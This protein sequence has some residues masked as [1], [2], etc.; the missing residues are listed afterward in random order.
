[1]EDIETRIAEFVRNQ[2]VPHIIFHGASGTG[3]RTILANMLAQI[4]HGV[5]R[6]IDANVLRVNCAHTKGIKYIRDDI[7]SFAKV[8][9]QNSVEVPFKSIVLYNADHLTADAQSALRRS[10]ELFS[11]NT[12]FFIVVR[13][14][15]KMLSPILSRFCE[16]HVPEQLDHNAN[17]VN[18]HRLL[19][20]P[21]LVQSRSETI[22]AD[23]AELRAVS[24]KEQ[25]EQDG[26]V[27][28]LARSGVAV[29]AKW[30]GAGICADEL[31]R[32]LMEAEWLDDEARAATQLFYSCTAPEI[33]NENLLMFFILDFVLVRSNHAFKV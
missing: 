28:D 1:M 6:N 33:K 15:H 27:P 7:K 2:R 32:V 14:K 24:G 22:L 12:R 5:R 9:I 3:K 13:D 29:V 18:M 16:I 21:V 19:Q 30:Y 25:K 26:Q 20:N 8:N 31:R 17:V 11:T 23:I 10:I 4:Y